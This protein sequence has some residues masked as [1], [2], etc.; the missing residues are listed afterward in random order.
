VYG[1]VRTVVWQGSAGDRRPYA[2]HRSFEGSSSPGRGNP[3]QT[4]CCQI[5][6]KVQEGEE[7]LRALRQ[8]K[9]GMTGNDIRE[10]LCSNRSW[11]EVGCAL[12]VPQR[13]GSVLMEKERDNEAP[14]PPR[15]P[16][17]S[18]ARIRQ[19]VT[20]HGRDSRSAKTGIHERVRCPEDFPRVI[21]KIRE[22]R[23]FLLHSH[24]IVLHNVP[25]RD[26]VI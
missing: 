6:R 23:K 3:S 15:P 13:Y 18:V 22:G 2:D 11:A 21:S 25:V 7:I 10:H 8:H 17:R 4:V 9:G 20:V 26:L 1:P 19:A 5:H 12:G 24:L 16:Q 14:A